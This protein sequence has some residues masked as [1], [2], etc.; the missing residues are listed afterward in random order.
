MADLKEE[1]QS[2]YLPMMGKHHSRHMNLTY[3]ILPE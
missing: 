1:R 2:C 3:E